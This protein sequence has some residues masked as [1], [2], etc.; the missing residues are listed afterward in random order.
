MLLR[1][2]RTVSELGG[3][4]CQT[5]IKIYLFLDS[6]PHNFARPKNFDKSIRQTIEQIFASILVAKVKPNFEHTVLYL[7]HKKGTEKNFSSWTAR[8]QNALWQVAVRHEFH[9]A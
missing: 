6:R 9:Y 8:P 7:A 3:K 4:L 5:A 2:A 1:L